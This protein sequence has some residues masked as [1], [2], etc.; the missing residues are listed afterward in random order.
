M[1]PGDADFWA[2]LAR[3]HGLMATW[4]LERGGDVRKDVAR[5][6]EALARA[7]ELNPRLGDAWW[8]LGETRAVQAR[9]LARREQAR[10]EDFEE[11]AKA[12]AQAL[13]LSPGKPEILLAAGL[14]H[15]EWAMWKVRQGEDPNGALTHAL[16][17]AGQALS[18]RPH[19]A[20]ARVLRAS[21]RLSLAETAASSEERQPWTDEAREELKEAL[22]SNPN[23]AP[24]WKDLLSASRE[25]TTGPS[26][27]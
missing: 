15:R 21:V 13:E 8:Y 18:E 3:A 11:A 24:M 25:R 2:N 6:E 4:T 5:A 27:P 17:L 22:A 20:R 19:W 9:W 14:F 7:R 10:S 12:F 1:L 26:T 16:T 23:L